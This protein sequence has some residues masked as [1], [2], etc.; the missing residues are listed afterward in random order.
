MKLKERF[1]VIPD[2]DLSFNCRT[3]ELLLNLCGIV[4]TIYDYCAYLRFYADRKRIDIYLQVVKL[5]NTP[6]FNFKALGF[7]SQAQLPF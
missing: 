1:F 2:Q 6:L 4:G 5:L 7:T 3:V